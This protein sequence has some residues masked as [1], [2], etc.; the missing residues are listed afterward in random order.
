MLD[1]HKAQLQEKLESFLAGELRVFSVWRVLVQ[2]DPAETIIEYSR[3]KK[4]DMIVMETR[5]TGV[6][7]RLILGSVT[8][9]VLHD[10]PCPVFTGVH[11]EQVDTDKAWPL[12]KVLCAVDPASGDESAVS[13]AASLAAAFKARLSVVHVIPAPPYHLQNY[14]IESELRRLL[15]EGSRERI[16]KLLKAAGAPDD[17]EIHVQSGPISKVVLSIARESGADVIVIGHGSDTELPGRLHTNG[18][19]IIRDSTC[20]V[21]SV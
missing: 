13:W 17:T 5:G 10:A 16:A 11:A 1:D 3:S 18:Y 4:I 20:P 8:A 2:G 6:F 7:R 15:G 9:K 12:R 14:A 19:S 21:I